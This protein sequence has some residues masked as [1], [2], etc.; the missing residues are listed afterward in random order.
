MDDYEELL[1][2][3]IRLRKEAGYSQRRIADALDV[4]VGSVGNWETGRNKIP[5]DKLIPMLAMFDRRLVIVTPRAAV[6]EAAASVVGQMDDARAEL[7]VELLRYIGD[8]DEG[9]LLDVL[10]VA[11]RFARMH[12]KASAHLA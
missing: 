6:Q 10:A 1:A 12:N 4:V 5:F 9:S 2:E 3:V 11:K 8:L 7:A